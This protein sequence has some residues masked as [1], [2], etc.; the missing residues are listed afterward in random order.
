[1]VHYVHILLTLAIAASAI[2]AKAQD[3]VLIVAPDGSERRWQAPLSAVTLAPSSGGWSAT[4]AATAPDAFTATQLPEEGWSAD[5]IA[6]TNLSANEDPSDG[7]EAVVQPPPNPVAETLNAGGIVRF[8]DVLFATGSYTLTD[9]AQPTL[10]VLY[11]ALVADPTLRLSIIGHTDSVGSE[12]D[13]MVLA[14]RRANSVVAALEAQ[15]IAPSRLIIIA[16]GEVE[17]IST[18][19]TEKGRQRNRRVDVTAAQ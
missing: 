11:G 14:Q 18:N 10:D 7:W 9:A 8:D 6:P 3:S 12:A 16:R 13:N 2:E 4:A 19:D 17:P 15:G 1:M 5:G